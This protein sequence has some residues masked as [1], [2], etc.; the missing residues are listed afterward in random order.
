MDPMT[1]APSHFSGRFQGRFAPACWDSGWSCAAQ[2]PIRKRAAASR[3]LF[4]SRLVNDIVAGLDIDSA[5]NAVCDDIGDGCRG[6]DRC[7]ADLSDELVAALDEHLGIANDAVLV[8]EIEDHKVPGLVHSQDAAFQSLAHL[9]ALAHG[10]FFVEVF[11]LGVSGFQ[12]GLEL[13]D[14][15][16]L[17]LHFGL[18][19]R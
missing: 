15:R 9:N 17:L 2:P 19:L 18:V 7:H 10:V 14:E 16:F 13:G 5:G 8:A 1:P 6:F 12:I 4:S 11:E 3:K